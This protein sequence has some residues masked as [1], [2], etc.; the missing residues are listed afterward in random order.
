MQVIKTNDNI[1]ALRDEGRHPADLLDL[2]ERRMADV[3]EAFRD[4]GAEWD[5]DEHGG[6]VLVERGDDVR[7]FAAVGLGRDGGGLL[8]ALWESC[9]RHA[10][11]FEVLVL[12][13]GDT[14]WTFFVPDAVWLDAELKAKLD[15]ESI[16]IDTSD[17]FAAA[18][19]VPF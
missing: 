7:D 1:A 3:A 11:A 14:G 13:C 12:F 8:G 10:E 6:F 5:P 18:V 9:Q 16:A 4:A 19:K 2:V 17:A 15:D